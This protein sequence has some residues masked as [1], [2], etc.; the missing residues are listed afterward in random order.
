MIPVRIYGL[1]K[2][3]VTLVTTLCV[4]FAVFTLIPN[5]PHSRA[6]VRVSDMS[7]ALEAA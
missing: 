5:R 1:R 7:P 2:G 3:T 4:L 6:A